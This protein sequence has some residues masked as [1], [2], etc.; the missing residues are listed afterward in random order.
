MGRVEPDGP[1]EGERLLTKKAA[2]GPQ[3]N[4]PGELGGRVPTTDAR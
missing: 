3:S 4:L 1:V 2:V